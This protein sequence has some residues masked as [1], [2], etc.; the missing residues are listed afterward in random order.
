MMPN[1]DEPMG[2][3]DAMMMRGDYLRKLRE[4]A[5]AYDRERSHAEGEEEKGQDEIVTL[6]TGQTVLRYDSFLAHQRYY[7]DLKH[8][9]YDFIDYG[10]TPGGGRCVIQQIK[11]LGKGGLCWDAAFSLAEHLRSRV[12]QG[13][14]SII[15][16]GAGTGICGILLAK[17]VSDCRVNITDLPELLPLMQQN[18]TRNFISELYDE[19]SSADFSLL[20]NGQKDPCRSRGT[21]T[22][23][24]FEWGQASSSEKYNVVIGADVVASLY[25]PIALANTIHDLCHANSRVYISYKGRLDGPHQQFEQRMKEL[26]NVVSTVKPIISRN[27]NPGVRIMEATD[28]IFE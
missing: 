17:S 18:V 20:Y 9:D 23:T 16:L 7:D 26:Y 15:E 22:A 27:R 5:E 14:Q 21:C 8:A 19:L 10:A 13:E 25:D 12:K 2:I 11:S 1:E 4:M 6:S 24:V 3:A 28:P